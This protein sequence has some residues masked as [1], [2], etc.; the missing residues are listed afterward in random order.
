[1]NAINQDGFGATVFDAQL[2]S[3]TYEL[4]LQFTYTS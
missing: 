3:M 1:M 4:C 2:L